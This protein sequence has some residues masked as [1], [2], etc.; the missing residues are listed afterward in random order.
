MIAAAGALI[1]LPSLIA[2]LGNRVDE[3][4]LWRRQAHPQ[5]GGLWAHLAMFVMRRPIPIALSVVALLLLLGAP[6][7]NARFS[8]PDYRSLPP[9][10]SSRTVRTPLQAPG[11]SGTGA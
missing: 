10:T 9:G 5:D 6:F 4:V 11:S 1:F 2:V 8:T 7:L 3:W